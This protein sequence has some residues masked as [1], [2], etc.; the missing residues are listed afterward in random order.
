MVQ[1]ETKQIQENRAKI[2]KNHQI[3]QKFEK[4]ISTIVTKAKT[5]EELRRKSA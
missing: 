5:V 4:E 3:I 2:N 1:L